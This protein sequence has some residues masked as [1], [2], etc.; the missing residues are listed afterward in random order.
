MIKNIL[1]YKIVIISVLIAFAVGGTGGYFLGN[2][3]SDKNQ[4]EK[5]GQQMSFPGN[6]TGGN[7]SNMPG[8]APNGNSNAYGPG[9]GMVQQMLIQVP[10]VMNLEVQVIMTQI[11][12][13]GFNPLKN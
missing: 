1:K 13:T 3:V 12:Q 11:Q 10:Q 2:Y 8:G 5:M 7:N 6:N 9:A 4:Q